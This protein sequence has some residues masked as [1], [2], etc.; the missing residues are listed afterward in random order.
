MTV[1][2]QMPSREEQIK[3]DYAKYLRLIRD[4]YDYGNKG[5]PP[6]V[7]PDRLLELDEYTEWWKEREIRVKKMAEEI[8]RG[9]L[10]PDQ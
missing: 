10:R 2:K 9:R 4:V 5:F 8:F 7:N 6:D 3:V 1:N